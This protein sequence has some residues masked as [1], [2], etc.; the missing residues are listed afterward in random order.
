MSDETELAGTRTVLQEF[1]LGPLPALDLD[2]VVRRGH[3]RRRVAVVQRVTAAVVVALVAGVGIATVRASVHGT[4]SPTSTLTPAPTPT[5][6]PS[7]AAERVSSVMN[8]VATASSV[9]VVAQLAA[10]DGPSTLDVVVTKDG[11]I[12]TLTHQG[13]TA[14]YLGVGGALYMRGDGLTGYPP[15]GPDQLAAANGRWLLMTSLGPSTYMNLTDL[16]RSFY[17]PHGTTP[18]LGAT[19][20]IDGTAAIAVTEPQMGSRFVQ[21]LE[22]DAPYR[23]VLI[24]TTNHVLATTFSDW[25]APAPAIPSAPDAADVYDPS[26]G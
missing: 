16:S 6:S 13:R 23:P 22:V 14:Q 3:R 12:G 18:I 9:H 8:A 10:V 26:Q 5:P 15:L 24:E 11:A 19:R 7:T 1:D 20:T 25:D 21:Y 2:D 17:P 4:P